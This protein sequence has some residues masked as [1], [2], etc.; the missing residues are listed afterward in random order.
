MGI[1]LYAMLFGN[2]PFQGNGKKNILE[3]ICERNINFPPKIY[4]TLSSECKDL[5]NNLLAVNPIERLNINDV[6]SHPWLT[7]EKL[8]ILL[9]ILS[10]YYYF[11]ILLKNY[12]R[13][14]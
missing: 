9:L 10:S 5:M 14:R 12:Q 6:L 2:L 3:S 13:R 8:Y 11:I 1:I 4:S 7:G